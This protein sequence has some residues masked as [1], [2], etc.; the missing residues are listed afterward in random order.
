MTKIEFDK[1]RIPFL[2]TPDPII[3]QDERVKRVLWGE[4]ENYKINKIGLSVTD[5]E[6]WGIYLTK[7]I[8][9]KEFDSLE[10]LEKHIIDKI[11]AR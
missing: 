6:R 8:M 10:E 2:S 7:G 4:Y 9:P 1:P 11:E 5:I 3:P